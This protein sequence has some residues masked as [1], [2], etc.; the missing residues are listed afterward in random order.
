MQLPMYIP[1]YSAKQILPLYKYNKTNPQQDIFTCNQGSYLTITKSQLIANDIQMDDTISDIIISKTMHKCDIEVNGDNIIITPSALYGETAYFEYYTINE[2]GE[3]SRPVKVDITIDMLPELQC[4]M[5]T[6]KELE[7]FKSDYIP[8][9]LVDIF[10]EWP[11]Y[12][13]NKFYDSGVTPAG[14]AKSWALYNNSF[15]CTSNTTYLTGFVSPDKFLKYE[16][17]ATISSTAADNDITALIIAHHWD[18]TYNHSLLAVR[19][20]SGYPYWISSAD[21]TKCMHITYVKNNSFYNIKSASGNLCASGGKNNNSTI[22]WD[23]L[24]NTR[25][26][27]VRNGDII[28]ITASPF[29]S[30]DL[31]AG[32]V[33]NIDLN[34]YSNLAWAK[35]ACRYGYGACSQQYTTFSDVVFTGQGAVEKDK[36]YDLETGDVWLYENE[37]W[38]KSDQKVWDVLGYPR[39]VTNPDNG[40]KY[41]IEYEKITEV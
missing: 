15:R 30:T 39:Y 11:R 28:T 31:S 33:I 20:G 25:V 37:V 38:F 23:S 12:Y 13:Y 17:E 2:N 24:G 21:G 3:R 29:K 26:R 16:H 32:E 19:D 9:T 7:D 1:G 22:N 34:D 35:E 18:G 4:Y 27:I 14:E 40:K 5:L 10:N 6:T 36:L 41:F 8:P